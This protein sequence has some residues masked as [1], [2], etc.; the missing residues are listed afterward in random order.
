[1]GWLWYLGTLV[2]VIGIVQ[3]GNQA[4]A[5]RYTYLPLIGIL[6]LAVWGVAEWVARQRERGPAL[7][8]TG[9]HAEQLDHPP[10]TGGVP[11]G[12]QSAG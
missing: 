4:F 6:V 9:G 12:G 8:A 7:H 5:D 10:R 3:V 1:M 2:P 11:L